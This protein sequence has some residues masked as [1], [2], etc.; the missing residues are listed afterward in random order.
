MHEVNGFGAVVSSLSIADLVEISA[1]VAEKLG[2]WRAAD[3]S[4]AKHVLTRISR[5][6]LLTIFC[7]ELGRN[8]SENLHVRRKHFSQLN[9]EFVCHMQRTICI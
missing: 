9:E 7:V 2:R 6:I 5:S 3:G 4:E 1:K 8:R